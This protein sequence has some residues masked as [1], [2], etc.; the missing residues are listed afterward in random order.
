MPDKIQWKRSIQ[1]DGS[2]QGSL[3]DP[4]KLVINVQSVMYISP[5]MF[6]IRN[7]NLQ[8]VSEFDIEPGWDYPLDNSLKKYSPAKTGTKSDIEQYPDMLGGGFLFYNKNSIKIGMIVNAESSGELY[9]RGNDYN[10]RETY[11]D[12]NKTVYKLTKG[13]N[14]ITITSFDT[15]T[16]MNFI[17]CF[18][19]NV[20]CHVSNCY[21]YY[22]SDLDHYIEPKVYQD[23]VLEYC[24]NDHENAKCIKHN[25]TNWVD[26]TGYI[27]SE[28]DQQQ[29]NSM[30][31]ADDCIIQSYN[32]A[33]PVTLQLTFEIS[34]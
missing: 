5:V 16:P 8:R 12:N 15:L 25:G 19:S 28:H 9:I 6:S 3:P 17:V 2:I 20:K 21:I 31:F 34:E 27:L 22:D 18:A 29:L 30:K 7:E 26:N 32:N 10:I 23:V 1:Q 24:F 33:S 11:V 13:I 4:K 14:N